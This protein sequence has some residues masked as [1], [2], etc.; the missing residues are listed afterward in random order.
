MMK[1]RMVAAMIAGMLA[2]A[3]QAQNDKQKVKTATADTLKQDHKKKAGAIDT[4]A[5]FQERCTIRLDEID[6]T[7]MPE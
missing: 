4:S 3:V 2:L 1:V 5:I 6:Y 7:K